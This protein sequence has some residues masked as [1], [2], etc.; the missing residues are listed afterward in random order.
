MQPSRIGLTSI[1]SGSRY[2][3]ASQRLMVDFLN[4]HHASPLA[5]L[6]QPRRP[7]SLPGAKKTGL[8]AMLPRRQ[9]FEEVNQIVEDLEPSGM[10]VP[11]LLKQYLK[12]AARSAGWNLDPTFGNVLDCLFHPCRG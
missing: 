7:H 9:N 10:G 4:Q 6:V 1:A 8:A 2:T 5:S 12:L 3:A 11:I